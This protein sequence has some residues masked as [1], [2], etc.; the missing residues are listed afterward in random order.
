MLVQID[1]HENH[2]NLILQWVLRWLIGLAL[3]QLVPFVDGLWR[4]L[5]AENLKMLV[6]LLL[7]LLLQMN[8]WFSCQFS[9]R[10]NFVRWTFVQLNFQEKLSLRFSLLVSEH[11]N[12][13]NQFNLNK[14]NVL[15]FCHICFMCLQWCVL[16]R[17]QSHVCAHVLRRVSMSGVHVPFSFFVVVAGCSNHLQLWP[18]RY[19]L[20]IK[21]FLTSLI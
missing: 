10:F 14:I 6:E 1:F 19:S 21:F 8:M 11:D 2:Q 7:P 13:W 3:Q 15:P 9:M 4:N 5:L 16:S 18:L 12:N 20:T 17:T